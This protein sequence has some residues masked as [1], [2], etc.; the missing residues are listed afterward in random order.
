M[1][2]YI[3]HRADKEWDIILAIDQFLVDSQ[4]LETAMHTASKLDTDF[5][6]IMPGVI[7]SA[8]KRFSD[9]GVNLIAGGLIASRS[10]VDLALSSGALAVSTSAEEIFA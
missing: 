8:I 9:R 6:E 4:G 3:H 5:V 7:P 2:I 10:D 1:L